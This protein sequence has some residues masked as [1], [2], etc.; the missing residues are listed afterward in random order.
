LWK[1]V[2]DS[3]NGWIIVTEQTA[4][5]LQVLHQ[6]E[7]QIDAWQQAWDEVTDLHLESKEVQADADMATQWMRPDAWAVNW[8]KR[9]LPILEVTL[10]KDRC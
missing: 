1:G 4:A 5:G 9:F 3:N 7:E 8:G 2:E 6:P 10:P